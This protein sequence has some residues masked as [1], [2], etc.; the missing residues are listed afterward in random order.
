MVIGGNISRAFTLFEDA[1][2]QGLAE[3]DLKIIVNPSSKLE[4]SA[5]M[6]AAMLL[7]NNFYQSIK[8]QLKLM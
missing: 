4:D 2:K 3:A 5:F 7:D 6:G 1:F 8:E